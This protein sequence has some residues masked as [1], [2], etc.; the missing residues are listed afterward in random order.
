[1]SLEYY[2][3]KLGSEKCSSEQASLLR[4]IIFSEK[5]EHEKISGFRIFVLS[6]EK[7]STDTVAL[8]NRAIMVQ[9]G[10]EYLG[11]GGDD[12][13]LKATIYKQFSE[14]FPNEFS[15][16]VYASECL[17]LTGE[18]VEYFY[19]ILKTGMLQDTKNVYYPSSEIFDAIHDSVHSFE[20]D[21]LLLEK[22][23]QPCDKASFDDW[24][25]E[26]KEQYQTHEQQEYLA[27]LTW[28]E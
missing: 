13:T 5:L 23:Y 6:R 20:F 28:K 26:F 4:N 25:K 15:F 27:K 21:M 16:K 11:L 7:L 12:Y 19:P 18:P 1:M 3:G 10:S 17:L 22:Y 9:Y 14:K 24:I 8:I 2:L